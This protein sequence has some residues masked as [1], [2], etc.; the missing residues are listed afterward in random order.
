MKINIFYP[1]FLSLLII[2]ACSDDEPEVV[3]IDNPEVIEIDQPDI[4][5]VI[6]MNIDLIDSISSE[7]NPSGYAP[8]SALLNIETKEE[9]RVEISII[10]R[11]GDASTVTKRFEQKGD[12][13]ELEVLG[14]Y[15]DYE[16]QLSVKLFNDA[17]EIIQTH[18]M[19]VQTDPLISDLPEITIDVLST[20]VT[21][22]FNLVN[23]FGFDQNNK[24][25]RAFMF[26]Q[27]GD[28][29]WYL[30]FSSHP[31]LSELFYD[32][33]MVRLKN[34]NL[35]FGDGTT[36]NVYETDLMGNIINTWSLKGNGFHHHVIEKPNGNLLVTINDS[37]KST[38]EDVVVELDRETGEFS[39]MW[40]LNNSLDNTRRA[41]PTNPDVL[42]VDWFHNNAIEYSAVDDEIILSGRT[43]GIVKLN[44]QN[45]IS[46]ILAPHKEWNTSGNG[47]DLSQFLLTPLDKDGEI[48]TDIDVLLGNANHPDFEWAWYQHSPILMPNGNIML[49]DNGDN[50]NYTGSEVYS[51]A[52]EYEIDEEN[53]TIRQVWTYGKERGRDTYSRI[54]SK[55]SYVSENNSVLFTPGASSPY[56]KVVEVDYS[57]KDVIFEAS[58]VPPNSFFGINFHN[59]LRMPL[60][61]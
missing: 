19:I 32:N 15:P 55:V 40:D 4:I 8:L 50:R 17:D 1:L 22:E 48:I 46:Y 2:V 20:S 10:G 45:E 6:D 54:V 24:P 41:W 59:V 11:N 9:V 7:L 39:N 12:L 21:P 33:G 29:R 34:G 53:K 3:D 60:Y 42:D 47:V 5:E 27:F 61:N 44:N 18:E 30:D 49:F 31:E 58:V 13:F 35:V 57:T 25:Q 38:I 23:Y 36:D 51:R 37:N 43:Q 28:I 52:V 16:N 56:G 26:D 14:L